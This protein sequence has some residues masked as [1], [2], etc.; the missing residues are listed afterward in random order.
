MKK[1]TKAMAVLTALI[2]ALSFAGCKNDDDDDDF[3]PT[4]IPAGKGEDVFKGKKLYKNGNT[5]RSYLEFTNDGF[6]INYQISNGQ[7]SQ[8]EKLQYT[9]DS[10]TKTLNLALREVY[11]DKGNKY[12]NPDDMWNAMNAELSE[13]NDMMWNFLYDLV[14]ASGEFSGSIS[15]FKEEYRKKTYNEWNTATKIQYST[16]SSGKLSIVYNEETFA[17]AN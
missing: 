9:C 7:A 2:V 17:E 6:V 8:K 14:K 11:D 12:T 13:N 10:E 16:T 5:N 3:T 15:E 4:E 1:L